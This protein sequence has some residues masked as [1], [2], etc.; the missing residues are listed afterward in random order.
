MQVDSSRLG[1]IVGHYKSGSTWL[2]NLLSLHPG[3]R[4][5][6]ETH[7]FRFSEQ[8]L[9]STSRRLFEKSAW[10]SPKRSYWKHLVSE[11]SR[12]VRVAA[13][14]ASG[15]SSLSPRDRATVRHDLGLA[16]QTRL[17]GLLEQATSSDE[18]CQRFFRFMLE[19]LRPRDYLIE[20]TPTNI[21]HVPK[22]K[23]LFPQAKLLSIYRDG[24]DVVT[25]DMYHLART[26][27]PAES[28]N[29]RVE[30]WRE[31]MEAQI[32]YQEEYG[33]LCYPMNNSWVIHAKALQGFLPIWSWILTSVL[34][35]I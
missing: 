5:V 25:S 8:N 7:I 12:P 17:R 13:G 4:G 2:L 34:P 9:S 11:W 22:I 21:F 29:E 1:F 24:R 33:I 26:E 28:L 6:G 27:K 3:I 35:K 30:K 31:A 19:N 18:C 32:T 14:T 23:N 15:Q 10:G 16:A 20:K